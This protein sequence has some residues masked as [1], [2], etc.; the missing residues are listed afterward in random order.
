MPIY[1]N[2][3]TSN[4]QIGTVYDNDGTANYRIGK[5]Y[6]NDGTTNSLIYS[7]SVVL[8]NLVGS[9]A[10]TITRSWSD[11]GYDSGTANG[12]AISTIAWH[13]YYVRA[14]AEAWAA[15]C[16]HGYTNPYGYATAVFIN[17]ISATGNGGNVTNH[18]IVQANSGTT[19]MQLAYRRN[20]SDQG[21]TSATFYM[22]VDLTEL[23]ASTGVTYTADSFWSLIGKSVFY[24]TKEINT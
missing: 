14:Y 7:G 9:A 20:E 11:H 15:G 10:Q 2:D 24:G 8:T 4:Y 12:N 22:I 1:D 5:V 23:E 21:S 6:D 19:Y 16:S 17:N 13:R 3:G 18:A